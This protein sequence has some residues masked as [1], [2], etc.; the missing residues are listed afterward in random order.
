MTAILGSIAVLVAF[1]SSAV[2]AVR[3]FIGMRN[4]SVNVGHSLKWPVYGVVAGALAAMSILEIGILLD[5]FSIEY[6]ANNSASTTPTLFKVAAGWAALEGS[7]VLWGLV[8][9]I[10]V[11]TVY[12]QVAK[13]QEPDQ[14]GAGALA[15]LGVITLFFFGLMLGA[16]GA[17]VHAQGPWQAL[18]GG[19]PDVG[20]TEG[21]GVVPHQSSTRAI[22]LGRIWSR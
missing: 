4:G 8:L 13:R 15:V 12:R 6:I 2:L 21:P 18:H 10:F 14:L 22:P 11:Y 17:V 9:A 7:I 20:P 5:D 16:T 3:G 19:S 1:V